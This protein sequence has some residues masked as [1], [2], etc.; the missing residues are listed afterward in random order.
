MWLKNFI[1]VV[2]HVQG[3]GVN[4]LRDIQAGL[5]QECDTLTWFSIGGGLVEGKAKV[6]ERSLDLVKVGGGGG[7]MYAND[8][9]LIPENGDNSGHGDECLIFGVWWV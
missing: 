3:C 5:R 7:V 1:V 4:S 2:K 6:L 8:A 9:F